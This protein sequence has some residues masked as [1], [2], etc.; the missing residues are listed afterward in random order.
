MYA[1]NIYYIAQDGYIHRAAF[2]GSEDRVFIQRKA[3]SCLIDGSYIFFLSEGKAYSATMDAENMLVVELVAADRFLV[4]AG[5]I[6]FNNEQG[7]WWGYLNNLVNSED[8]QL[9]QV[10][11]QQAACFQM[12]ED[13]FYIFMQDGT[14]LKL[15]LSTGQTTV[16]V[17]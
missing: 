8:H 4:N 10:S 17:A 16:V 6:I 13:C 1:S 14:I 12:G 9:P 11:D 15:Q 2:V 3:E 7:C 5:Y